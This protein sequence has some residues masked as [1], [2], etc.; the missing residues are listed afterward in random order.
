MTHL[1]ENVKQNLQPP[2]QESLFA[3]V[4]EDVAFLPVR[5]PAS[6]NTE[7]G[8]VLGP[9]LALSEAEQDWR[10]RAYHSRECHRI[11]RRR[12]DYN[13][14][15]EEERQL[16][17][18]FYCLDRIRKAQDVQGLTWLYNKIELECVRDDGSGSDP[19]SCGSYLKSYWDDA[20]DVRRSSSRNAISAGGTVY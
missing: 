8:P 17:W 10:A 6:P 20:S 3:C 15:L 1:T 19:V 13:F 4:E 14:L 2:A 7:P 11:H 16:M 18:L 5:P 9:L 12:Q